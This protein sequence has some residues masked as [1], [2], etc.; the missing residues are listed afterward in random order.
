MRSSSK[1]IVPVLAFILALL[2]WGYCAHTRVLVGLRL[3]AGGFP[4]RNFSDLF[5]RWLGTRALLLDGRDPYSPQVTKE[6]Q[7]GYYGRP[8]DSHRE[9][10]PIDQQGFAY[11]L[12]VVFMLAP[13]IYLPF[14]VVKLLFT[15]ILLACAVWTVLLWIQVIGLE[16]RRDNLLTCVLLTLAAIPY[17][18]GVQFQQL[19]VLVAFSLAAAMRAL[20][21]KKFA[22]AGALLA[23]ATVKP[24]LAIYFIGCLLLWSG[25]RWRSRK[26]LAISFF[27]VLTVLIL[28]SEVLLPDWPFEFLAG[29]PRY[30]RYTQATTGVHELFGFVGGTIV[31]VFLAALIALVSWRA[32]SDTVDSDDF[33][34]AI[35]S[36]LV[37][38]CIVI[39]SLA[40][41]NQVLLVPAY[42]L[43]AK[44]RK[45]I[46]EGG[47]IARALWSG[48]WLTLI[49]SWMVGAM[50]ATSLVLHRGGSRLWDLPL[51]TNP[52]I[53]ISVFAALTPLIFRQLSRAAYVM[54]DADRPVDGLTL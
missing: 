47:R 42:L 15:L 23:I 14:T 18:S 54:S 22:L 30:L 53:P 19:S 35:S 39:P 25:W 29:I 46:W 24:Q 49:W 9:S 6:I 36:V 31:F 34:L 37:F 44:E 2:M 43:L 10:D 16:D 50:L 52:L 38:T 41:H 12:F 7:R 45:R 3:N 17:A 40:P 32:K 33:R 8:I 1:Y 5:P 11:P 20:A 13:T 51:A 4:E 21:A 27:T 28:A 26:W 48:A